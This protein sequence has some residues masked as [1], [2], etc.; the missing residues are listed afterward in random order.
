MIVVLSPPGRISASTAS[1]S[2]E[3]RTSTLSTPKLL[4]AF[5]CASKSPCNANTPIVL[6]GSVFIVIVYHAVGTQIEEETSS[7]V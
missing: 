5:R 7:A 3:L 1:R 6:F 2:F 4:S